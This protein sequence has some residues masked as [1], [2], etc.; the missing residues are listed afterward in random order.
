MIEQYVEGRGM[1]SREDDFLLVA[2]VPTSTSKSA[3]SSN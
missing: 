3:R 2:F 1:L